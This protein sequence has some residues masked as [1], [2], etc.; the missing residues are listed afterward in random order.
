M[1]IAKN[2][3]S[4]YDHLDEE[5]LA[6]FRNDGYVRNGDLTKLKNQLLGIPPM[7]YREPF[8]YGSLF[9]LYLTEREKFD[10]GLFFHSES[11]KFCTNTGTE[12]LWFSPTEYKTIMDNAEAVLSMFPEL[13]QGTGA[14]QKVI[15]AENLTIEE[16]ISVKAKIKIDK[17]F[18]KGEHPKYP[19][20]T[21]QIDLK[22]TSA[23]S[24]DEYIKK[25]YELDYHRNGAFYKDV[26]K[27]NMNILVAVNRESKIFPIYI[28]KTILEE[29][30]KSYRTLVKQGI[31]KGIISPNKT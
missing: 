21:V 18:D 5:T 26:G 20:M 25:F 23:K 17:Y 14:Y 22:T 27:S 1:I 8:R 31:K 10:K 24:Y 15:K 9:D 12:T 19:D 7:E 13:A 16:G 6:Y 29:G 28:A 3:D 11:G 30:R 4:Y 2:E